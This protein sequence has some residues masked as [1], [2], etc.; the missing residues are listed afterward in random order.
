MN[1]NI[2][3]IVDLKG[4]QTSKPTNSLSSICHEYFGKE[5]NKSARSSNWRKRPL[6]L[7]QIKYA[8]LDSHVLLA[9]YAFSKK[10]KK[11]S[12]DEDINARTLNS[13]LQQ[14]DLI[15]ENESKQQYDSE[16]DNDNDDNKYINQFD[17]DFHANIKMCSDELNIQLDDV[18]KMYEI[19]K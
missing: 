7:R 8:A 14:S 1:D 10:L 13:P 18:L 17:I 9:L 3:N 16:E 4:L 12:I 6:T 15:Q 5:L 11:T 19:Q 2:S